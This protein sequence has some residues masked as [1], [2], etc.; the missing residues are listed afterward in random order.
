MCRTTVLLYAV[1]LKMNVVT[2]ALIITGIA[3]CAIALSIYLILAAK[4]KIGKVSDIFL[5]SFF[6]FLIKK[7]FRSHPVIFPKFLKTLT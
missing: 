5:F 2:V 4:V 6:A 7:A 3:L 1:Q